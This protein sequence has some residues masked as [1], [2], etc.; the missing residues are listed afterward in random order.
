MFAHCSLHIV[1]SDGHSLIDE[2]TSND[3]VT[4]ASHGWCDRPRV[5]MNYTLRKVIRLVPVETRISM[6]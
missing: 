1:L 2:T 5:V 3:T 6:H 4:M